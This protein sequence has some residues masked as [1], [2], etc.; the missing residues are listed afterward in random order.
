[1]N[2]KAARWPC[3][4]AVWC[5]ANICSSNFNFKFMMAIW[6]C[7]TR[8][9]TC[10]N[11]RCKVQDSVRWIRVNY[12]SCVVGQSN[13]M[14]CNKYRLLKNFQM[15]IYIMFL[16]YTS[17]SIYL[18]LYIYRLSLSLGKYYR[19]QRKY[20]HFEVYVACVRVRDDDNKHTTSKA[21]VLHIYCNCNW[22]NEVVCNLPS[23]DINA[24]FCFNKHESW[25]VWSI[26]RGGVR[27]LNIRSYDGRTLDG[28]FLCATVIYYMT[29]GKSTLPSCRLVVSM[30]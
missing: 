15:C 3:S 24:V 25:A 18:P 11:V 17:T 20:I 29:R 7:A 9:K 23:F 21:F 5:Y 12:V 26:W 22:I 2:F 16:Q 30:F 13:E 6:V 28:G 4:C 27:A 8:R 14:T 19:K 1:M 10:R